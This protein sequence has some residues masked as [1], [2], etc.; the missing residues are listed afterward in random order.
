MSAHVA[1]PA[2]LP[3]KDASSNASQAVT[4]SFEIVKNF[5]L[6]TFTQVCYYW[7]YRK[8]MWRLTPQDNYEYEKIK[9]GS[10][11]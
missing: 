9:K 5:L 8:E 1:F 10:A 4:K 7:G 3:S 6:F 2:A 11:V